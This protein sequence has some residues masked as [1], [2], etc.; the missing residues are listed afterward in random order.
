LK[1]SARQLW[2]TP[3]TC[4]LKLLMLTVCIST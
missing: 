2:K 4:L 3:I 1:Q